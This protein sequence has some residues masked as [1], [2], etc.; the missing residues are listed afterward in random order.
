MDGGNDP[1]QLVVQDHTNQTVDGGLT[2]AEFGI[3][4]P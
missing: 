2:T 1:M 3:V 4:S